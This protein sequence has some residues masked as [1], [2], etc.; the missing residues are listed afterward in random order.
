VTAPTDA[1]A[2]QGDRTEPVNDVRPWGRFTRLT[3]NESTT[4]KV[5]T[6]EPGHRLSL[7]RHTHRDELWVVL[8]GPVTAVVGAEQ[9]TAPAG[10]RVWI[11][12]GTAHR[13][14]N[15]SSGPVRVLE[16]AF[17]DFDEADIE[18]LA[19]DYGR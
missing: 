12:R 17:G 9:I 10:D 19:D 15:L 4:V 8:D 18:R 13:M 2:P 3:H 5:I 7:Q 14:A 16:I 1:I 6:V 11:P